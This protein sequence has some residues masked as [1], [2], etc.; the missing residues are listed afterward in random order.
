MSGFW[1]AST[2]LESE[3]DLVGWIEK[4]SHIMFGEDISLRR[5]NNINN[6]DL[7]GKDSEGNAVIVEVKIWSDNSTNRRDQ[8]DKSVGQIIRYA[9][10]YVKSN[11]SD[12]RRLFIIGHDYSPTVE[13]CCDFLRGQG[14]NIQHL[15]VID[16]LQATQHAAIEQ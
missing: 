16:V 10:D 1:I 14:Y 5:T 9:S 7:I 11:P 13:A 3:G 8:E 4:H 6:P 12:N 15:S 2:Y